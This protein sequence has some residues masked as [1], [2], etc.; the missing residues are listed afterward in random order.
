MIN[1]LIIIFNDSNVKEEYTYS[2]NDV[3]CI[4]KYIQVFLF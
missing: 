2:F 3:N 4:N 1:Q